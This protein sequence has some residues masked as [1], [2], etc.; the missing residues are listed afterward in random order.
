NEFIEKLDIS[1]PFFQGNSLFENQNNLNQISIDAEKKNAFSLFIQG[2]FQAS[3][4][5]FNQIKEQS[6]DLDTISMCYYWIG[7]NYAALGD[8]YSSR[9]Y[10]LLSGSISPLNLYDALSGQMLNIPSGRT[11]T[12]LRS[13]F[14]NSWKNDIQMWLNYPHKDIFNRE[15]IKDAF[16]LNLE[17]IKKTIKVN[18]LLLYMIHEKNNFTSMNAMQEFFMNLK[19][20]NSASLNKMTDVNFLSDNINWLKFIWPKNMESCCSSELSNYVNSYIAWFIYSTGNFLEASFFVSQVKDNIDLKNEMNNFL[21]FVFYPMPFK[22]EFNKAAKKYN[23][24][25]DILYAIYR[26][27]NLFFI[28]PT[29]SNIDATA[30]RIKMLLNKYNNNLVYT[31]AAFK[32]ENFLEDDWLKNRSQLHDDVLF[33]ELIPQKNVQN[34]VR[35]ILRNYYNIKWIYSEKESFMLLLN[36][37]QKTFYI[38]TQITH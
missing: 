29:E 14:V 34:F 6:T 7:R 3:I 18:F 38:R 5:V 13:P 4:N 16:N 26:Q 31:L 33:I 19:N 15:N 2:K 12:S 25:K 8:Y 28:P 17:F 27:E 11:S 1:L 35:N 32:L 24:D 10:F 23:I 22:F 20:K 30:S 21:Y 9:Q 36:P 37:P